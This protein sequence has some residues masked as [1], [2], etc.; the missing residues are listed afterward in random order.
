MK[1]RR[2]QKLMRP[3][4]V[5]RT[6]G[7]LRG[8]RGRLVTGAAEPGTYDDG[9]LLMAG[10]A[11][12]W[13]GPSADLPAESAARIEAGIEPV[14]LILPGLVDVHCHGG[15]G[16]SFGTDQEGARAAAAHHA[17]QG[18]TSILA[19]LVSAPS[20]LLLEQIVALRGLVQ[21]G[22]LAGLHLEGPFI[23][24]SM[25]GAQDPAAIVDGDPGLLRQWFDAAQGTIRSITLAP[26]TPHF[27]E[28]VGLCREYAVLPSLGHTAATAEVTRDALAGDGAWSATHLFNR[29]PA[30]GHRDAGPVPVM[31]Q[32]AKASPERMVLELVADGIH[33]D[34]EIV[35]MVFSL[36]GAQSVALVTDAM[37]AA[38]MAD[39]PYT[40][41]S[42]DVV[43]RDGVARLA[44]S[45][46]LVPGA[47]AG[48]TSH[49]LENVRNCVAWGIP[50]NDVVTAATGAPARLMGLDRNGTRQVDNGVGRRPVGVLAAGYSADLLILSE[51]LDLVQAYR[52]GAPLRDERT[53]HADSAV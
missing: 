23:T 43:V 7:P 20:A 53:N 19:S 17:E 51:N 33:L 38:G 9:T 26:E 8:F 24:H 31:L 48:A 2:Q 36:A 29:M 47:I 13:C 12:V 52:A 42:M 39:G 35:R 4:A 22:T 37:A 27:A 44:T 21:D 3:E 32:R 25:C 49:L 50:L 46:P 41:G 10:G 40:L 14:D 28:L 16:H 5:P 6:D 11:I 15:L 34:P 45:D 1:H 18:S 30:I